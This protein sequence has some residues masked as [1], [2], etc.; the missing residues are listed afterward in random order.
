MMLR[1]F[2]EKMAEFIGQPLI[3]SYKPGAG[4]TVGAAFVANSKP[5]GYTLVGTS[6]GSIVLGP[7]ASKE[8]KFNLDSFVPVAAVAEGSLILVVPSSSPHKTL[9]DLIDYSKKNPG[10]VSYSSSG[11]MG[12]V[13]VLTEVAAK[14]AGVKWNHIAFQGS[15]PGVT[16]LLGGHVDMSSSSAGPVQAHIKA[17]TLRPLAVYGETRM[18]AYPEVPTLKELGY[19]VASPIVYG[20][21]APKGTPKEIVDSLYEALKKIIAKYRVEIETNLAV[22]GAEVRLMNPDDYLTHLRGQ[23]KLYSD[24]VQALSLAK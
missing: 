10:K 4:G 3:I 7:L 12:A 9:K 16:A 8:V 15:G 20:L 1:P 17:G 22:S 18:K 23:Q 24:A 6:I 19:N 13:H 14:E 5:D 21:L 2:A 11:T